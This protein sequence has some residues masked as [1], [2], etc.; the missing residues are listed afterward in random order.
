M[1]QV[2]F[3]ALDIFYLIIRWLFQVGESHAQVILHNKSSNIT[4]NNDKEWQKPKVFS[5]Q[6]PGT[7]PSA[8]FTTSP[9]ILTKSCQ[10]GMLSITTL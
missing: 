8:L 2:L 4:N 1:C 10:V 3:P 5:Y 7:L 6:V 9:S